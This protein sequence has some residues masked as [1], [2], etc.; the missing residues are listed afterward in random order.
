VKILIIEDEKELSKS[1][2]SYLESQHYMCE[3]A[4]S[5]DAALNKTDYY[6]YDCIILDIT[7]P[8]GSGLE[9]LRE[10][11][12][13]KKTDGVIIISAKNSTDDK[14]LGLQLG[15]DDYLAKPFHLPE[16]GARVAAV[17]RRK[18]F[19]GAND[20]YLHELNI[21]VAA[22]KVSVHQQTVELTPK[23]FGLLLF[24]VANKNRVVS[25]SAIAAHLSG[26][27]A[28]N[29]GHYD[30]VYAHIKNLKKKLAEGGAR[31]FIR[32]IYGVGYKFE[33]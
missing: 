9:I 1:I 28:D 29:F 25:K 27:D 3:T 6:D 18:N 19:G 5:C 8:D 24:L 13:N 30:F 4:E 16:L 12:R 15:A 20:I 31:D 11:Q 22:M 21:N 2:L 23:E 17:I 14:I 26:E 7:L 10:L 32:S 33:T